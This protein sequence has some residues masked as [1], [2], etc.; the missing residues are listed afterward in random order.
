VATL[1]GTT[2]SDKKFSGTVGKLFSKVE[3]LQ[4]NTEFEPI[5]LLEPLVDI[6]ED[7]AS[8]LSTDSVVA[9][10]AV[11]KG[12]LDPEVAALKC[13]QLSHSSWLICGMRCLLLYMSKHDLGPE[14]TEVLK[15]LATWVTQVYLPMFYEIKVNHQ[16]KYGS[17]HMIVISTMEK[18]RCK[19]Q[20]CFTALPK[21][22]VLVGPS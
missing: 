12:K 16:I 5:P 6:S 8:K 11:V 22:R 4:R 14:D 9:W 17:W 21:K 3:T 20:E 13:G 7:I 1:D 15:L 19:G 2:S 10:N 18:A